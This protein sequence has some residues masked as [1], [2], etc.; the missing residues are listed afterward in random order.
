MVAA[1]LLAPALYSDD[2]ANNNDNGIHV[3]RPMSCITFGPLMVGDI[4]FR[5]EF[6]RL[7]CEGLI[8]NLNIVNRGDLIPMYPIVGGSTRGPKVYR[9]VGNHLKLANNKEDTNYESTLSRPE[10]SDNAKDAKWNDMAG[11]KKHATGLAK[12]FLFEK[13]FWLNHTVTETSV[14]IAAAERYLQK[15]RW[16]DIYK[17][18]NRVSD[19]TIN[20]IGGDGGTV[21]TT[22]ET[23]VSEEEEEKSSSSDNNLK[24]DETRPNIIPLSQTGFKSVK[25]SKFVLDTSM[26]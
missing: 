16:K 4:R 10:E 12:T 20:S 15:M 7:E 9:P 13:K 19:A 1:F 11:F 24:H 26:K 6:Q 22:S 17:T 8:N 25:L 14:N 2:V 3:R 5:R 21:A 23:L 18:T